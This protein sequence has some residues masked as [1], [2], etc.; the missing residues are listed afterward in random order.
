MKQNLLKK[1]FENVLVDH[2]QATSHYYPILKAKRGELKALKELTDETKSSTTP[3]L[4]LLTDSSENI[5]RYL[6]SYWCFKNNKVFLD[7]YIAFSEGNSFFDFKNIYDFLTSNG[8]NVIPV[9]RLDYPEERLKSIKRLIGRKRE[10]AVRVTKNQIKPR[11]FDSTIERLTSILKCD[12]SDISLI[13]DFSFIDRS[14]VDTAIVSAETLLQY[15][16][17]ANFLNVIIAAGSF[18]K[19]LSDISPDTV[20][21]HNRHEWD[22]WHELINGS[23]HSTILSYADYATRHPIY[24]SSPQGFSGSSSIRYTGEKGFVILRG[25]KPGNHP[26]G[27]G[28]YHKKCNLLLSNAHYDGHNFSWADAEIYDCASRDERSGNPETWVTISTARH[29]EKLVNLLA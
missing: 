7:P 1:E 26:D 5:K 18:V 25:H 9:L 11:I 22:M 24:D 29:I 13:I 17:S 23:E 27:M 21:V 28:Q 8:V 3:I 12:L 20:V 14:S 4:E 15:I 19:D 6:S 16:D 2:V 10:I